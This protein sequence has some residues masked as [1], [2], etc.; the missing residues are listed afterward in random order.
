MA[1]MSSD[2]FAWAVAVL[3]LVLGPSVALLMEKQARFFT[4]RDYLMSLTS[5]GGPES[6]ERL[7]GICD[8]YT[9]DAVHCILRCA[10]HRMNGMQC[11]KSC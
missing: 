2:W 5:Q 4:D 1:C 6:G 3:Q 11:Y 8:M 9:Q 7:G 10:E